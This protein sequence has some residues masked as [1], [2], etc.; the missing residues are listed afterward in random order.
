MKHQRSPEIVEGHMALDAI[1]AALTDHTIVGGAGWSPVA[2][3]AWMGLHR[4]RELLHEAEARHFS[5]AVVEG[6]E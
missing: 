6:G 1:R 3:K 4:L 5:W 2:D